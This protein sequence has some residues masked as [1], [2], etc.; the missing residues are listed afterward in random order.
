MGRVESYLLEKIESEGAIHITLID[1]ERGSLD[2][3]VKVACEAE[4]GG[5]AAIMVGSST[6][7]SRELMDNLLKSLKRELSIPRII[8]PNN[9]ASISPYADAVWF[10]S[11]LN[12]DNPYFIVGVQALAAPIVKEYR[13][14]AIPMGYLILGEGGA[15]GFIGQ[16]RPIPYGKP[17]ISAAYALAAQ[18]LGMRFIYLEAGSGVEKPI[19]PNIITAVRETVNIPVIVGGGI[20]SAVQAEAATA[21]GA[22]I[23]VTGTAVEEAYR[24]K[25]TV[26]TLVEACKRGA[27]KYNRSH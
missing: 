5:T 23:V 16:A 9:I 7:A 14:E 15:A 3:L 1:P 18:F 19:P 24:V 17:E 10:M 2:K 21:S 25:A 6:L 8:F 20:R 22:H 13:L 11:L 26:K 12:S 4:E 27:D